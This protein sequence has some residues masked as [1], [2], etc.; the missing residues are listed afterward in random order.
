MWIMVFIAL[1]KEQEPKIAYHIVATETECRESLHEL[2][3][4]EKGSHVKYSG[5]TCFYAG[6]H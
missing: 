3:M 5:G 2:T 6:K 4:M 1:M